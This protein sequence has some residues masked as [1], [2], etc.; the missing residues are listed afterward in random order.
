MSDESFLR[1]VEEELRS[2]KLKAFWK[3][4]APFIIGGAVLIVLAVAA[5]EAWKW[6]RNSTAAEA[7]ERYYAA[8]ALADSGDLAG[9]QAALNAIASDGPNGYAI[10]ARFRAASVLAE[11][12]DAD[13]AIAAYDA[14]SSSLSDTR[15]RELALV[16][17]AYLA[18]DHLDLAGVQARAGSLTGDESSMRNAARE[19]LGLAY[20][21][22]GDYEAARQNFEA[23]AADPMSG[24]DIQVRAYVYLEQLASAGVEMSEGV[25]ESGIE[26]ELDLGLDQPAD[27]F[28][29]VTE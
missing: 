22:A 9:A 15:L 5:N 24:Q 7:S 6:Y 13:G 28:A 27:P 8:I 1:E 3:R 2:D 16:L 11:Q 10:L 25:L 14:L 29:T 19:A 20:F 4:F 23:I 12:G 26:G 18:V 21:K 17:G